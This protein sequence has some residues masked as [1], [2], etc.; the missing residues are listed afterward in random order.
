MGTLHFVALDDPQQKKYQRSKKPAV[1]ELVKGLW[2][3]A[4][5]VSVASDDTADS[6]CPKWQSDVEC[7]SW[8][9]RLVWDDNSRDAYSLRDP[10]TPVRSVSADISLLASLEQS[11]DSDASVA[12]DSEKRI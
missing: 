3:I 6:T 11:D 5:V 12:D 1:K 2:S 8:K 10:E 9:F 7:K 4:R